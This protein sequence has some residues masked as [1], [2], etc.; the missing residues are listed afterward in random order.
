[1]SQESEVRLKIAIQ[2]SG[3]LYDDSMDL[4]KKCGIKL[5]RSKDQL[6]CRSGNFPI[7]VYFVRDDDIPAFVSE[8]VC[9]LGIVGENVLVEKQARAAASAESVSSLTNIETLLPLG[10]GKCRLSLAVPHSF[11]YTDVSSLE[12][13][14]IATSYK[15]I[16][17][18]Y[19]AEK[20]VNAKIVTMEGAVEIAPRTKLADA[21]C[22]L[23]S[24]GATL[25]TNGLTE[26]DIVFTSQSILIQ[27]PSISDEEKDLLER[28]ILRLKG[29]LR[30]QSSKY[31]MLHSPI[32]KLE[33]IKAALPGSESPTVVPLEGLDNTVA[34]HAVCDESVFW[35]TME[36]LK[37]KGASSILVLPIEKMLD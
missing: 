16:L 25:A 17:G 15:G 3:R 35:N 5:V 1:M 13:K 23:V 6:F 9:Q 33:D 8:G 12:G 28:F 21:I 27:N 29:V 19:L 22:D 18:Q 30:S 37:S 24:T 10:F 14:T 32:D 4:L 2:K 31:I 26:T 20:N 7:D 34:V 11:D 36:D